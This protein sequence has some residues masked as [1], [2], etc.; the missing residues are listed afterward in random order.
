M[1]RAFVAAGCSGSSLRARRQEAQAA[2]RPPIFSEEEIDQLMAYVQE[3]GGGP[4]LPSGDLRDGDLAEGGELFRLNCAQC[5]NF[6]G[7][8]GALSSGKRAPSLAEAN[9]LTIY[10]A[11]LHGLFAFNYSALVSLGLSAAALSGLKHALPRLAKGVADQ[12]FLDDAPALVDALI[13]F[14]EIEFDG[15]WPRESAAA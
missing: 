4:T 5:H 14:D 10:A 2:E 8:G 6:T 12:L 7:Q 13:A 11:M 9:D 15:H 3:N 1:S